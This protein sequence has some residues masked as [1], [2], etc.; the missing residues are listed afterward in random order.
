MAEGGWN[1]DLV[2]LHVGR[3]R[4]FFW[5]PEPVVGKPRVL[6]FDSATI[7]DMSDNESNSQSLPLL[8]ML[9]VTVLHS[10]CATSLASLETRLVIQLFHDF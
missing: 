1:E 5:V 3:G 6:V 7:S 2:T 9:V 10:S 8:P 4:G